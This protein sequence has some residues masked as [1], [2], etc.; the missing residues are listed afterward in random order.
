MEIVH[1]VFIAVFVL[2]LINL[3]SIENI[4]KFHKIFSFVIVLNIITAFLV[5]Y[6][7]YSDILI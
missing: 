6:F 4:K 3:Y 5:Y 1:L 7:Y 2:T